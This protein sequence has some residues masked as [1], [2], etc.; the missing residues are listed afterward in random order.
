MKSLFFL[1][2]LLQ[3]PTSQPPH[4]GPAVI[5]PEDPV[6][7]PPAPPAPSSKVQLPADTLYVIRSSVPCLVFASPQ[8]IL[9]VSSDAGPMKIMAR[10]WPSNAASSV[11]YA[12]PYLYVVQAQASGTA[13]LIVIPEGTK[14]V[15][16][17]TRKLIESQ[18][19]PIPP[20]P[21]P[22]PPKPPTPANPL[23]SE[24]LRVLTIYETADKLTSVQN[25]VLKSVIPQTAIKAV[26][27]DYMCLDQNN[28]PTKYTPDQWW[29][30]AWKRKPATVNPP[31]IIISSPKG[32][33][34]GDVPASVDDFLALIKKYG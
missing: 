1:C 27:G 15:A 6:P 30:D 14:D 22:D 26:A 8:G 34:E 24:K 25:A 23:P 28:D 16:S 32:F 21:P 7:I 29:K 31:K 19:A 18:L 33:F 9:S 4:P 2:V 13:E 12:E 3:A 17:V 11:K 20:P 5:F 10:I